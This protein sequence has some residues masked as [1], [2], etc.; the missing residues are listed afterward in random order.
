VLVIFKM[1][2][3]H[4]VLCKTFYD[5][6]AIFYLLAA[7][8]CYVSHF[9]LYQSF[10]LFFLSYF[11]RANYFRLFQPFYFVFSHVINSFLFHIVE[12]VYSGA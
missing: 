8:L 1:Y 7:I 10:Y 11:I 2:D 12:N 9:M 5:V 4:L 6:S 3:S